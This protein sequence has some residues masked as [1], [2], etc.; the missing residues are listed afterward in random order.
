MEGGEDEARQ[1]LWLSFT[2]YGRQGPIMGAK[3]LQRE[4]RSHPQL[5]L[6]RQVQQRCHLSLMGDSL[7]RSLDS[8]CW[9]GHT[10]E[11]VLGEEV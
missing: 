4:K 8:L 11:A 10:Q 2:S 6:A 3:S 5:V 9:S 7:T 1:R